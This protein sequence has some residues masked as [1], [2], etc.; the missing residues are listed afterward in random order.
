MDN[1]ETIELIDN[2]HQI[3]DDEISRLEN[4]ILKYPYFQIG[5]TL[6]SKGL[7]NIKS[8]RYNRQLKKAAAYSSERK[9]LFNLISKNPYTFA[10]KERK[11]TPKEKNISTTQQLSIGEPLD[12]SSDEKHSFSEWLNLLNIKKINRGKEKKEKDLPKDYTN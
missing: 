9:K 6:L 7:L 8:I 12:F 3:L 4:I 2:P 1:K 5:Q 10:D 11:N